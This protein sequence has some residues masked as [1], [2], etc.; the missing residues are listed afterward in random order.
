M[1][2]TNGLSGAAFTQG[3]IMIE[4]EIGEKSELCPE[5]K[6]LKKL[7]LE[8]LKNALALPIFDMQTGQSVAVA[9]A[10]NFDEE[11]YLKSIDEDILMSLSTI[12]AASMFN[13]DTL[14]GVMSV[15]DLL[16]A[17]YDLVTDAC[18]FVNTQQMVTKINRSAE[19]MF[20]TT[21]AVSVGVQIG[22]L[23]GKG[24]NRFMITFNKLT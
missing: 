14:Q 3:K 15:S 17:Q 19:V 24:N 5:E 8:G 2:A 23:L 4:R 18:V 10:Y 20:N 13:V 6:D 22:E 1:K 16:Q 9:L 11:F 21:S 12:Y 7:E